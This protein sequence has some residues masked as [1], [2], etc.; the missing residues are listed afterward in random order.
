MDSSPP[1]T[2][3]KVGELSNKIRSPY[4]EKYDTISIDLANL[5]SRVQP[6]SPVILP[7]G[8]AQ[9]TAIVVSSFKIV[10]ASNPL[11]L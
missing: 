8:P 7:P 2:R 3:V 11:A 9:L 10:V 5:G 1:N 6:T 4:H